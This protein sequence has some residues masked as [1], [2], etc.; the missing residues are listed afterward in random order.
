MASNTNALGHGSGGTVSRYQMADGRLVAK[1]SFTQQVNF[2]FELK[3]LERLANPG[4]PN[5]V[6][7]IALYLSK[8]G[9]GLK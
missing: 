5:I 6:Q 8:V 7:F 3:C 9:W 1:K 4:H 2:L